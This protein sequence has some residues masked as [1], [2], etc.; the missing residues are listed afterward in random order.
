MDSEDTF[1]IRT[2]GILLT[3]AGVILLALSA[4]ALL[5]QWGDESLL[6]AIRQGHANPPAQNSIGPD[7]SLAETTLATGI[8]LFVLGIVAMRQGRRPLFIQP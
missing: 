7:P 3:T 4:A 2:T 6:S 8:L 1:D 5:S